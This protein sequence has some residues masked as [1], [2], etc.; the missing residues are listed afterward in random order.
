MTSTHW[1][2]CSRRD[3]VYRNTP[4]AAQH[5]HDA[6]RAYWQRTK[7]QSDIRLTYEVLHREPL[8]GLAHWRTEYQVTSDE[9]F[10][11]WAASTGTNLLARKPGDPLPRL[12]LDGIAVA[13]IRARWPVPR[14]GAVVAQQGGG[15][16][17]PYACGSRRERPGFPNAGVTPRR[18]AKVRAFPAPQRRVTACARHNVDFARRTN[19]M[20]DLFDNPMGLMG[21]EFVE[22]ASPTPG[23]LEPVLE[24]LGFTQGRAASLQG[25]RAVP[26]GRHQ[27]HRQQRARE[28]R[29]RTSR[30]STGPSACGMG[31]RV[32]DSHKAY[33][34]RAGVGR[35]AGGPAARPDGAASCRPSRA[36]AARRCISSTATA[37]AHSI[38]D[39]D[40][41]FVDGVDRHPERATASPP[42]TT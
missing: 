17:R 37:T 36:S 7:L 22:F 3:G 15:L 20:A 10:A 19:R 29:L 14:A 27:L 12:V 28:R 39:I 31:F 23:V 24:R 5:G 16:T 11:I 18:T 4:F 21:F 2:L 41:K 25:R 13:A 33:H 35:A 32:R 38:Y 30:R 34:A 9:L 42:S 6:I 26:A 1:P 8:G 40:F